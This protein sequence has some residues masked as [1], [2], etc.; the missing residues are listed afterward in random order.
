MASHLPP[1][2]EALHRIG[3]IHAPAPPGAAAFPRWETRY[4]V[5]EG[6]FGLPRAALASLWAEGQ[7]PKPR[8]PLMHA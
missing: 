8:L 4:L 7:I 6:A 5:Y 1:P 2:V 3:F